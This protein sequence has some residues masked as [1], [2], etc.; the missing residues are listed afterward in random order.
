M[1]QFHNP[2][3]LL[4]STTNTAGEDGTLTSDWT[5]VGPY[6]TQIY[7]RVTNGATAPTLPG[8]IKPQVAATATG[9]AY[10]VGQAVYGNTANNGDVLNGDVFISPNHKWFRVY[11]GGN[12]DQ[13]VTVTVE[14]NNVTYGAG[15][16]G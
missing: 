13:D 12:T 15:Y 11:V 5:R 2:Q 6:G 16:G 3:V 1:G 9:T 14:Y 10:D 4:A 8:F 7:C